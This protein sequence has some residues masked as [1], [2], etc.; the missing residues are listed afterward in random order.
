MKRIFGWVLGAVLGIGIVYA[1]RRWAG[2]NSPAELPSTTPNVPTTSNVL[3]SNTI[4]KPNVPTPITSAPTKSETSQA[5]VKAEPTAKP[6]AKSRQ[7]IVHRLEPVAVGTT[8]T[9]IKSGS[10]DIEASQ[11]IAEASDNANS[12]AIEVAP[13]ALPT[14]INE[15][16]ATKL[17]QD[18]KADEVAVEPTVDNETDGDNLVIIKGVGHVTAQ[19]L[20][21]AGI[22]TFAQLGALSA[23]ELEEKTGIAASRVQRDKIIEQAQYLARGEQYTFSDNE[24]EE[25]DK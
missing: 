10:A 1:L 16:A 15:T 3:T 25:E 6:Q 24:A 12:A 21:A 11:E 7:T 18:V 9:V 8:K 13:A 5:S 19:K 20:Q 17:E 22:T 14:L 4:K 23:E 2:S